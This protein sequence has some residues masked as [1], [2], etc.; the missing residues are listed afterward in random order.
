[1]PKLGKRRIFICWFRGSFE[2]KWSYLCCLYEYTPALLLTILFTFTRWA[3]Q[4]NLI[5]KVAV[6]SIPNFFDFGGILLVEIGLKFGEGVECYMDIMCK[7]FCWAVVICNHWSSF[8]KFHLMDYSPPREFWYLCWKLCHG[9]EI[10]NAQK[11]FRVMSQKSVVR[12]QYWIW[13]W[14]FL[15][16]R[17]LLFI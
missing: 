7:I 14:P 5:A 10:V 2:E 17:K 9:A 1:M 12:G 8:Y 16:E 6:Q 13:N 15:D 11:M 4:S 3:N